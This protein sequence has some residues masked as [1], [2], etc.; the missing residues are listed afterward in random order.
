MSQK[1]VIHQSAVSLGAAVAVVMAAG[2]GHAQTALDPIAVM[3]TAPSG[4]QTRIGS[5]VEALPAS[6]YV[7]GAEE[8]ENKNVGHYTDLFRDVPGMFVSQYG[9]G[10]LAVGVTMRG[11]A[12]GSHGADMHYTVDGV[13]VN[14]VSGIHSHNYPDLNPILPET[15]DRIEIVRG[16][17]NAEYG[18]GNVAGSAAFYTRNRMRPLASFQGGSFGTA[19][20][21]G[22][23]GHNFAQGEAGPT[24]ISTVFAGELYQTRGYRDNSG[25][26][27]YNMFAKMTAPVTDG[28]VSFR[29][30]IYDN[31]WG[32]PDYVRT[33][34]LNAG[35]RSEKTP[36]SYTDGGYKKTQTLA[37]TYSPNDFD[38]GWTGAAYIIHSDF[39][40]IRTNPATLAQLTSEDS[41]W[42]YGANG[43]RTWTGDYMGMPTQ[44]SAGATLRGDR[45]QASRWNSVNAVITTPD[46]NAD[47]LQHGLGGFGQAQFKPVERVKITT[48][49]RYDHFFYDI[50]DNRTPA[51]SSNHSAGVFS[52][53]VGAAFQATETLEF[54]ANYGES[55]RS[56][57][58][59]GELRINPNLKPQKIHSYEF[60]FRLDGLP[61]GA[62]L[63]GS[64]WNTRQSNEIF[65]VGGTP[66]NLGK[67]ER[68]GYDIGVSVPVV[69]E[70]G[71]RLAFT[72]DYSHVKARLVGRAPNIT[73]PQV[74]KYSTQLALR[75]DMQLPNDRSL[76]G[77]LGTQFY[78]RQ[79]A[80]Q[81]GN[82]TADPYYVVTGRLNYKFGNGW[83]TF[84]SFRW[85]PDERYS[86]IALAVSN[87]W[88]TSPQPH[89]TA[90]F[91][92]AKE[93]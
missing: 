2:T 19:R 16:P 7:M 5:N 38:N 30:Q 73:V 87:V 59:T 29:V 89:F 32:A 72:A 93:F 71:R 36:V 37:V 67:S 86:E 14:E 28:A 85:Y 92:L 60:G 12:G 33:D 78:G 8:I 68:D 55:F 61:L 74:P 3:G 53:K 63:R 27:R 90:L 25:E 83:S 6:T 43:K 84:G 76:G 64:V 11:Y 31:D 65:S 21:F 44:L 81:T 42:T 66:Q 9:Q 18:D 70:Q 47:I 62:Q 50:E 4:T 82:V 49:L 17:F 1:K 48:G 13:P 57:N 39:A 54:F 10:G 41:R 40:R 58:A 80:D 34:F 52:P 69:A 75:G 46:I 15:I 35:T 23:F 51:N 91:G 26:D 88:A 77:S 24:G 22:G 56:P 79:Y 45:I 20:A